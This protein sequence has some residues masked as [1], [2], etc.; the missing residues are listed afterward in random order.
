MPTVRLEPSGKLLQTPDSGEPLIELAER[1]GIHLDSVCGGRGTCGRCRVIVRRGRAPITENDREHLSKEELDRGMRLACQL[2]VQEDM[3]VEIPGNFVRGGQVILEDSLGGGRLNPLVMCRKVRIPQ[4]SLGNPMGDL[5]RL[6]TSLGIGPGR[7][8][9]GLDLL[10]RLPE[11]VRTEDDL[12]AIIREGELIGLQREGGCYGVAVDVG[13]TTI[14]AYLVDLESGEELSICSDM[15][16]QIAFGDDVISRITFT[17]ERTAGR[18]QMKE[19]IIG[20]LNGLVAGC[21]EKAAVP[22]NR[23]YEIVAVG[24]TAMHHLMI[25]VEASNLTL[26]PYVPVISSPLDVRAEEMGIGMAP[27]G[28]LHL[29]PNVAGFVGSDHIAGLLTCRLWERERPTLF[30]DVGTNGEISVGWDGRI[31][32]TSTAAG[33]AFEGANLLYGMRATSGAIDSVRIS[34]DLEVCYTTV[35][36]EKPRGLC[37]SGVVDALSEMLLRGIVE[38]SGRIVEELE[39]TRIRVR[40][41]QSEFILASEEETAIGEAIVISQNDVVQIQYAKAAMYAGARLLMDRM[42]IDRGEIDRILLAGAFGN[43]IPRDSARN[44][45]LIP[46]IPL[47]RIDGIGNAAGTGAK[48][49]LLDRR[50]RSE[51]LRVARRIEYV[52][53]AAEPTFEDIFF[54]A[55]Y[56]PHHDLSLFPEVASR[57][58]C[59]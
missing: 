21:C 46:E 57:L 39:S 18:L 20:C 25:G 16:P 52:E 28:Y 37:G 4:P 54:G 51:A 15:N 24:N 19:K 29:P 27:N 17:M 12:D 33:P 32:S 50:A 26:C 59:T 43:Y 45:G 5:E 53:L 58:P 14:V 10:R 3:V 56:L 47:E 38:P 2:L 41:G 35:H 22:I 31:A 30:M 55:M 44:I 36:G 6:L 9:V 49:I 48:M 7:L 1:E 13:T 34:E 23:I 8:S 42:Q 40:N 11:R